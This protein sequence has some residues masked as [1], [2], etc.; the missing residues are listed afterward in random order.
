MLN[1]GSDGGN[2][3][4]GCY[5]RVVTQ[6]ARECQLLLMRTHCGLQQLDIIVKYAVTKI[7]GGKLTQYLTV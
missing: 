2:T 1:Y 7:Q 4:N 6:I 5:K 3:I